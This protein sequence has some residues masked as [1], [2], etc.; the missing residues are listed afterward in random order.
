MGNEIHNN[1]QIYQVKKYIKIPD[2]R[3]FSGLLYVNVINHDDNDAHDDFVQQVHDK[4]SASSGSV[5][6]GIEYSSAFA[7]MSAAGDP[8]VNTPN[9]AQT[10]HDR[11]RDGM[12]H[13]FGDYDCFV[14]HVCGGMSLSG[15][16][17][18]PSNL[19]TAVGGINLAGLT[20]PMA[21]TSDGGS[22]YTW[23]DN[24]NNITGTADDTR[25][26]YQNRTNPF[27]DYC[28][29]F[30]KHHL[31]SRINNAS[32]HVKEDNGARYFKHR[33]QIRS[34]YT[35]TDDQ[36]YASTASINHEYILSNGVYDAKD[37]KGTSLT[38]SSIATLG[39]GNSNSDFTALGSELF[40]ASDNS[41]GNTYYAPV[42][43]IAIY[44]Q[45]QF[46]PVSH[47]AGSSAVWSDTGVGAIHV[48]DYWDL[49]IDIGLR[50]NNASGSSSVGTSNK[51]IMKS[52]INVSFQP[53][54]ETQTFSVDD[55]EHTS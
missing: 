29:H 20:P 48:T 7:G 12:K 45:H 9:S 49:V 17:A 23:I 42:D 15:G 3:L 24:G 33:P 38:A 39:E 21:Q 55:N 13:S 14:F 4:D 19:T 16:I 2:R 36:H 47:S 35:V 34:T 40:N 54:G 1:V 6:D 28:S 41:D 11:G 44:G 52:Q 8:V 51:A 27:G 50:G 32:G 46:A 26:W 22:T 18:T 5:P 37:S 31:L 10:L 25:T 53:F 43:R 30:V